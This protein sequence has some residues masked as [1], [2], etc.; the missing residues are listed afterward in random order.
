M[1][2][3]G[4]FD[5]LEFKALSNY[6]SKPLDLLDII[7]DKVMALGWKLCDV[8]QCTSLQIGNFPI[9]NFLEVGE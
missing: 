5:S 9:G 6:L 4:T 7:P 3:S 8:L 2:K 1:Q